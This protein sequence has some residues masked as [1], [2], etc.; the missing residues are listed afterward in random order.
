MAAEEPFIFLFIMFNN[1]G[2]TFTKRSRTFT[3]VH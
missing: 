2:G 3:N 1:R